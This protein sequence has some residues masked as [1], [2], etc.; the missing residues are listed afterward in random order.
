[1]RRA[2]AGIL[3]SNRAKTLLPCTETFQTRISPEQRGKAEW[4][5][6]K[7]GSGARQGPN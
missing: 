5:Q 6:K 7:R 3:E 2:P 1:M 4:G